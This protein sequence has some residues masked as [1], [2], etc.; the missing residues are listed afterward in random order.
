MRCRLWGLPMVKIRKPWFVYLVRCADGSIYTGIS[1]DV[2]ARL[3]KHNKGRGARYTAQRR[4][5][6]LLHTEK[7]PDQG[8]AMR[9][10]R[11][12]KT[13]AKSKKEELA[14]VDAGKRSSP[15]RRKT[16]A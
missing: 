4:P 15:R 3:E 13:W 2:D 14:R 1:D 11:Q 8:S 6:S 16:A 9:R 12:I 7:H 5:V 10:E